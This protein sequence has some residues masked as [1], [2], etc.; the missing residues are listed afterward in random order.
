MERIKSINQLKK[1]DK[2]YLI[3][4]S[5]E[6]VTKWYEFLCIHPHNPSYILAIDRL[7][8]DAPKLYINDILGGPY[9]MGD[10]DASFVKRERLKKLQQEVSK[11]SE[12]LLKRECQMC[13]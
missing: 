8:Q 2:F 11:L 10:F 4:G 13:P 1:G 9:Y 5:S 7:T 12:E 6:V 3:D